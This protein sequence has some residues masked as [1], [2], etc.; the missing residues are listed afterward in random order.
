MSNVKQI[1]HEKT[2]N[3]GLV[4]KGEDFLPRGRGFESFA[5]YQMDASEANYQIKENK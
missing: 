2:S 4:V 3:K 1:T 5:G